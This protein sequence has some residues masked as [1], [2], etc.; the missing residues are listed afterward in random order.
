MREATFDD[1]YDAGNDSQLNE[2]LRTLFNYGVAGYNAYNQFRNQ[3]DQTPRPTPQTPN[4]N[5]VQPSAGQPNW[6]FWGG[7]G[8][9]VLL[10]AAVVFFALRRGK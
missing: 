5:E 10:V 1:P 9:A 3:P 7:I 8:G 4:R 2:G 6:R